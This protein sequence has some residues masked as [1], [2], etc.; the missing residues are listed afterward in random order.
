MLEQGVKPP[1]AKLT[2]ARKIAATALVMW[3]NQ[4]VYES[5]KHRNK[6]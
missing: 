6:E 5:D 3:K 4:E 2:L 1:L